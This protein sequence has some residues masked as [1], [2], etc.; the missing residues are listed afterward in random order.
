M[1]TG[2]R[3]G[4]SFVISTLSVKV[5]HQ[6][7]KESLRIHSKVTTMSEVWASISSGIKTRVD[8]WWTCLI[9][10]HMARYGAPLANLDELFHAGLAGRSRRHAYAELSAVRTVSPPAAFSLRL[11]QEEC[12]KVIDYYWVWE[13]RSLPSA[14]LIHCD[15][16]FP[17]RQS[18]SL[19]LSSSW[20]F[21]GS[22]FPP[23]KLSVGVKGAC[24]PASVFQE[25]PYI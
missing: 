7:S 25:K 23:G 4:Y 18:G 1:E 24:E 16:Q 2:M 21:R 8:T 13:T 15:G 14:H 22:P 20:L 10:F 3:L 12:V 5:G 19:F 11:C 17:R 9:F 6:L